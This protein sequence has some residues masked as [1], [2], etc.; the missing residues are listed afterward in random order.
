MNKLLS[1]FGDVLLRFYEEIIA[2]VWA[3]LL[4]IPMDTYLYKFFTGEWS[5]ILG[6]GFWLFFALYTAFFIVSGAMVPVVRRHRMIG[7]LNH[8]EKHDK[9]SDVQRKKILQ[10]IKDVSSYKS[11]F[12]YDGMLRFVMSNVFSIGVMFA[13]FG[14]EGIISNVISG[15]TL[16]VPTIF[17]IFFFVSLILESF[18]DDYITKIKRK[19][20]SMVDVHK[21]YGESTTLMT[22]L[23]SDIGGGGSASEKMGQIILED[24][25]EDLCEIMQISTE[26]SKHKSEEDDKKNKFFKKGKQLG[27]FEKAKIKGEKIVEKP[28]FTKSGMKKKPENKKHQERQKE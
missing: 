5:Y 3:V 11:I 23:L 21:I 28:K 6:A 9:I 1:F 7:L 4:I 2:G 19:H 16:I 17:L 26:K 20:K 22:T 24:T 27:R 13:Y 14:I 12:S 10:T 15:Q 18:L 25:V 8:L